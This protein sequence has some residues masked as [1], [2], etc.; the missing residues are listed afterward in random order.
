M[1]QETLTMIILYTGMGMGL[2]FIIRFSVKILFIL[3]LVI[4]AVI[5]L[6]TILGWVTFDP[7][8]IYSDLSGLSLRWVHTIID[9]VEQHPG[10]SL[11]IIVGVFFGSWLYRRIFP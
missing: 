10:K 2:S 7:Q 5:F 8:T 9:N 4:F 6:V 1:S 3:L 11:F